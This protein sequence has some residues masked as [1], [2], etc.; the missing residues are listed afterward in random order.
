MA[1]ERAAHA[2]YPTATPS[3]TNQEAVSRRRA[4]PSPLT[5]GAAS[6]YD[7]QGRL[8]PPQTRLSDI[9][10][11]DSVGSTESLG[12]QLLPDLIQRLGLRRIREMRGQSESVLEGA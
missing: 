2:V 7:V 10:R 6:A 8:T 9:A 5:A 11:C 3:D 1:A 12:R 4:L